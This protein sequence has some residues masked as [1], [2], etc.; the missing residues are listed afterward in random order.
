M[1][2]VI[3]RHLNKI[4]KHFQSVS[5]LLT[6][7]ERF[8]SFFIKKKVEKIWADIDSYSFTSC[9]VLS[10]TT[11]NSSYRSE[12]EQI[13]SGEAAKVVEGFSSKSHI[14]DTFMFGQGK[15][16]HSVTSLNKDC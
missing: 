9:T 4:I 12:I 8:L 16:P 7:A 1:Y 11:P 14:L 6:I 2:V 13:T 15:H 10:L 5:H 3:N